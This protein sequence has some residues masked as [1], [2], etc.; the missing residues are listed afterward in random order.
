MI[1]VKISR[2]NMEMT[3]I[4][5]KRNSPF[6]LNFQYQ[7][8]I[9]SIGSCLEL[10]CVNITSTVRT[11]KYKTCRDNHSIPISYIHI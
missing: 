11:L 10:I 7:K 3:I 4:I 9:K 2:R 6:V 1:C 8:L 5:I